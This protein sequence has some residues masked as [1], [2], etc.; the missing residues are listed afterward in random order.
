LLVAGTPGFARGP[1]AKPAL[2]VTYSG[3]TNEVNRL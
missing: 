2:A 1:T 3:V